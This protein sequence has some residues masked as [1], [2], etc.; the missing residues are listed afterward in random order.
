MGVTHE[1]VYSHNVVI[2]QPKHQVNSAFLGRREISRSLGRRKLSEEEAREETTNCCSSN[3]CS[4]PPQPSP[5]LSVSSP[6]WLLSLSKSCI[7][8]LQLEICINTYVEIHISSWMHI[9]THLYVYI[10]TH[11][12]VQAHTHIHIYMLDRLSRKETWL[13]SGE[14]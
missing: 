7:F 11:I 3:A 6:V 9:Y 2:Q 12:Y 14:T 5:P 1:S 13:D 8:F 10:Y 4:S